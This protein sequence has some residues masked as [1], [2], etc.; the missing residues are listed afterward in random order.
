MGVLQ[1]LVSKKKVR[2]KPTGVENLL[3]EWGICVSDIMHESMVPS[4]HE[5]KCAAVE[6]CLRSA[7][8]IDV[9]I[10]RTRVVMYMK[11]FIVPK[12]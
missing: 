3:R 7:T 11:L 10:Y 1:L 6:R 12:V 4:V 9:H 2:Y 8:T 5:G